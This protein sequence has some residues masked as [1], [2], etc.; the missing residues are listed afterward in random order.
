MT[1][2]SGSN[3][4]KYTLPVPLCQSLTGADLEMGNM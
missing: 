2:A 1:A 4:L 3:Q